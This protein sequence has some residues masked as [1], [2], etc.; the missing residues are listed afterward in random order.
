MESREYFEVLAYARQRSLSSGLPWL[1]P[2]SLLPLAG[3]FENPPG[4][5]PGLSELI[6]YV[7]AVMNEV[8]LRTV[9][10][11]RTVLDSLNSVVTDGSPRIEGL[12]IDADPREPDRSNSSSLVALHGSYEASEA[13]GALARLRTM[14]LEEI[15]DAGI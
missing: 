3:E 8:E 2:G 6:R 9:E 13:L 14:L 4:S 10:I 1:D 15:N 12:F 7:D 11:E 5:P